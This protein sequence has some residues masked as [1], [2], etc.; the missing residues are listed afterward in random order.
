MTKFWVME[1]GKRQC[2]QSVNRNGKVYYRKCADTMYNPTPGQ[3]QV[4]TILMEASH[5]AAMQNKSR[6]ELLEDV[7]KA[8]YHI[9]PYKEQKHTTTDIIKRKYPYIVGYSEDIEHG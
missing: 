5:N 3:L 1:D 2:Y 6:D 9:N 7:A 8:P 4:R